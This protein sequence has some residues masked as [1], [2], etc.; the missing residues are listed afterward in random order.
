MTASTKDRQVSG[1]I[2]ISTYGRSN[3]HRSNNSVSTADSDCFLSHPPYISKHYFHI[4]R[5]RAS[6]STAMSTHASPKTA[7]KSL[8]K[9]LKSLHK[10][11]YNVDA[12][13]LFIRWDAGAVIKTYAFFNRMI[14]EGLLSLRH[15]TNSW[16]YW[17][18]VNSLNPQEINRFISMCR[19]D[20][21][22]MERW[23]CGRMKTVRELRAISELE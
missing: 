7:L 16:Q 1:L 15:P 21:K 8:E 17:P 22:E 18:S 14:Y 13:L 6:K 9:R 4:V 20:L 10:R 3:S 5:Q 23:M 2:G 12:D 11:R 19:S